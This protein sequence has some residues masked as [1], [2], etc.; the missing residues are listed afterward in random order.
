MRRPSKGQLILWGSFLVL[1]AYQI[2]GIFPFYASECDG[3]AIAVGAMQ[4]SEAGWDSPVLW[5]RYD[6][7]PGTYTLPRIL[8]Q[9]L[10]IDALWSLSLLSAV[11]ALAFILV[12]A[13]LVSRITKL[14]FPAAGLLLLSF[15]EVAAAGYY[16]N[17]NVLAGAF[18]VSALYTACRVRTTQ[19][20]LPF[21][22][23]AGIL[24][25]L[26]GWMRC[27]VVLISP[28]FPFLLHKKSLRETLRN[29][30]YLGMTSLAVFLLLFKVSGGQFSSL[31]GFTHGHMVFDPD[32]TPNLGIPFLGATDIKN[33]LAFFSGLNVFWILWGLVVLVSR[34]SWTTLAFC[35]AGILP[36]YGVYFGHLTTPKYLYYAVPFLVCLAGVGVWHIWNAPRSLR[37][38]GLWVSL[39]LFVGQ[40]LLGLRVSFRSKP[41]VQDPPPR[42]LQLI[43]LEREEGPIRQASLVLG[44]GSII[45][46]D[47]GHR[48]PS[49]S[50]FFPSSWHRQKSLQCDAFRTLESH[51]NALPTDP[52][53]LIAGSSRGWRILMYLLLKNGYHCVDTTETRFPPPSY[54]LY[55]S[56][57][58]KGNRSV[59]LAYKECEGRTWEILNEA[60]SLNLPGHR[61]YVVDRGWE[62]TLFLDKVSSPDK[63]CGFTDIYMLAAYNL[64]LPV[65]EADPDS[66]TRRNRSEDKD[67]NSETKGR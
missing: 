11:G 35:L 42:L 21:I 62:E 49:G 16:V 67:P 14:L 46:T 2:T 60:L 18:G 34:K 54:P 5:Y 7:Q 24:L 43:R 33:H 26:A 29:T 64:M 59:F 30:A 20:P 10:G 25:G 45:N 48:V 32:G 31:V 22:G 55:L 66:A 6:A 28:A 56:R 1:L 19:S 9:L 47:D 51:L 39:L 63:I 57:W 8:H 53:S 17:S 3:T 58:K 65:A 4:L 61:I 23:M 40:Y 44:A 12:C 13:D 38:I 27:D 52:V 15:Q 50:L 37:K 41:W 36:L